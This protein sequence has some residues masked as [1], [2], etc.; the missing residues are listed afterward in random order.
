MFIKKIIYNDETN[1]L[2]AGE[3]SLNYIKATKCAKCIHYYKEHD[4]CEH[5]RID[6]SLMTECCKSQ[7]VKTCTKL[8]FVLY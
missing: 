4:T 7:Y 6:V 8:N 5:E 2:T 3:S 1:A